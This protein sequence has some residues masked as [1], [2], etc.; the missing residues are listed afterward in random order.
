MGWKRRGRWF[1]AGL[2][3]PIFFSLSSFSA[4]ASKFQLRD[5]TVYENVTFKV[6]NVFKVVTISKDDWK[7]DVS[8]TDIELIL[9]E[10]GTD[11]TADQIGIYGNKLI[12]KDT[13]RGETW[14]S[15]S[16]P[17]VKSRQKPLWSGTISVGSNFS[18]PLGDYYDGIS[19]GVGFGGALAFAVSRNLAIRLSVS[20]SG[21]KE[22]ADEIYP[23]SVLLED[24]LKL[25]A[26][27]YFVSLEYYGGLK[28]DVRRKTMY[29]L[30]SGLGAISHN[31]SGSITVR[32]LADN[33]IYLVTPSSD[34]ETKFTSTTGL[35]LVVFLSNSMGLE[36]GMTGDLV[37]VGSNN[38][39]YSYSP[40]G[41]AF[42]FDLK[43]GIVTMF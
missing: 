12:E 16:D 36:L 22:N 15:K 41:N 32:D 13:S 21:M 10:Q 33:Q 8:Y 39:N 18:S 5:G 31:F 11:I 14:E 24:N 38:N 34:G 29:Y 40:Y 25:N 2:V 28:R 37:F 26:W 7:K 43:A 35:G 19:S 23:N 27:R 17:V 42:V 20:K 30:Y 3:L 1:L 9:D 4:V 6:N